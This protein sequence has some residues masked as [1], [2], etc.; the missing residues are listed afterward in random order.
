MKLNTVEY[1]ESEKVLTQAKIKE[2]HLGN[3]AG[4][5]SSRSGEDE[6]VEHT[7]KEQL[8]GLYRY[9]RLCDDEINKLKEKYNKIGLL[10]IGRDKIYVP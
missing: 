6:L 2:L 10:Y 5:K 9:L 7:L 8:D 4:V 3:T 1:W